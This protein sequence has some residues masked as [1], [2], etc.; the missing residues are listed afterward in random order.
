LPFVFILVKAELR[1]DGHEIGCHGYSHHAFGWFTN[2]A[3][4]VHE[5]VPREVRPAVKLMRER[6]FDPTSFAYPYGSRSDESDAAVTQLFKVVR[7]TERAKAVVPAEGLTVVGAIF[8]DADHKP[9]W[10]TEYLDL[11]RTSGATVVFCGHSIGGRGEEPGKYMTGRA[12]LDTICS[13][14]TNHG[15]RFR[16]VSE[17][18]P[19]KP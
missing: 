4:P 18:G 15:M 8:M 19:R 12:T 3:D 14:V 13:Y 2:R 16:T 9:G 6:G 7:T 10:P 5:F 11:A 1:D 17:L